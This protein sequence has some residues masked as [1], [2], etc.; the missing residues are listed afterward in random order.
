MSQYTLRVSGPV[1]TTEMLSTREAAKAAG[2]TFFYT[3]KPCKRGH[4]APRYTSSP[5]C[6][7]CVK[8]NYEKRKPKTLAELK[9]RYQANP[10]VFK[11]KERERA[12]R[13]PKR[14]WVKHVVKNARLRASKIGVPFDLT[15]EYV[16]SIIPDEC[17]VF[18]TPFVFVMAHPVLRAH[19]LTDLCPPKGM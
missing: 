15:P 8:E 12:Y 13:N 4:V 2:H 17:P 18:G 6:A 14:Y 9:A 11:A 1:A 16:M 19:R 7:N 5:L 3:G 10:E